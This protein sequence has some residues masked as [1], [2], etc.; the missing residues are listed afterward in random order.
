M[1]AGAS[2]VRPRLDVPAASTSAAEAP[3]ELRAWRQFLVLSETLHYGRAAVLLHMT[4]PPLT[5][6]IQQLEKR[7]GVALF[8]RTRRS[9]VLTPAG[10]ALV[11]PVRE[12]MRQASALPRLAR[13]AAHGGI[14]R[15][16][17]GFVSPLGYGPLPMWMRGL[18]EAQPGLDVELQEAT[19]DV[20]LRAL[21]RGE[22]DAGCL[23]HAP[24]MPP[25]GRGPRGGALQRLSLGPEPLVLALPEASPLA[26]AP[27][28]TLS[29]VLAEPLVVFPRE[30]LPSIF[31][32]LITH[33][34]Q[35]G[36]APTIAQQAIQMQ[37]IVNLVSAGLGVAWVP[38]SMM[39]LQRPGVVYR[40][41]PRPRVPGASTPSGENSLVWPEPALPAVLLF[42]AHVRA[43]LQGARG[44]GEPSA[45][46]EA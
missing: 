9:V 42:V 4:Q 34:H 8:E 36:V 15:L 39:R 19:G 20:Q 1:A 18:R 43:T 37:T 35:H 11:E 2:T 28:L 25:A 44:P 33:Y 30:I 23:L 31:D 16:R 7:L 32:A 40:R 27:R 45:E 5:Q 24:G 17:L 46:L 41:A 26:A 14:G 3:V 21:E 12:L 6:A 29:Q 13:D 38:A 22:L 10:A